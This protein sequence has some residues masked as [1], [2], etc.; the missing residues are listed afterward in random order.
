MTSL[1]LANRYVQT[2]RYFDAY[3]LVEELLRTPTSD[4]VESLELAID[5]LCALD[6]TTHTVQYYLRLID[7]LNNRNELDRVETLYHQALKKLNDN[8]TIQLRAAQFYLLRKKLKEAEHC[9]R[10]ALAIDAYQSF[11]WTELGKLLI[12]TGRK[13]EAFL[14]FVQAVN[15]EPS[16]I[17]AHRHLGNSY[18]QRGQTQLGNVHLS[19]ALLLQSKV[20]DAPSD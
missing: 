15:I 5:C 13:S 1:E 14:A 9:L 20:E 3:L 11:A 4:E 19:R 16:N 6:C 7:I 2:H 12:Q 17:E 8:V 10:A 18:L